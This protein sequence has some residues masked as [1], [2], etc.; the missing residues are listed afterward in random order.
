MA[1]LWFILVLISVI[2]A[3]AT[4]NPQSI[5]QGISDG[6]TASVE[7]CIGLTGIFAIWS[8]T[9]ECAKRGG[10]LT[11]LSRVLRPIIRLL[12][13]RVTDKDALEAITMNITAN[14]L[15]M[16]NAATPAGQ[17]AVKLLNKSNPTPGKA[18]GEMSMLLIINNSALTLIPTT[19]L[20][21]RA[22][23]GSSDAA[24]IIPYVIVSSLISTVIA[25][26]LGLVFK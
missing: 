7:L 17:R 13:K 14:I 19:I 3:L 10:V 15:G 24:V 6:A 26:V 9:M 8:G 5:L 11:A 1:V 16:G 12:F 4:L 18:T 2:Y 23:A 25:V 22:A 21:L 20:T